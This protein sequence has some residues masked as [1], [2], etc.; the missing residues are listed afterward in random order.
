MHPIAFGLNLVHACVL[1]C[2]AHPDKEGG[3]DAEFC[4]VQAAYVV[5]SDAGA[6]ARY[7]ATL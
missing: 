3:T 7:D 4:R 1:Q 6:R 2:Q 5:L